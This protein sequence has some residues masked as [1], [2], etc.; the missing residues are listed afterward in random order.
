MGEDCGLLEEIAAQAR[1][2]AHNTMD[3][4]GTISILAVQGSTRITLNHTKQN[5]FA[6]NIFKK[7][8]LTNEV[9]FTVPWN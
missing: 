6:Q 7:P 4:P 9:P 2:K 5:G 8:E 3:L 1:T